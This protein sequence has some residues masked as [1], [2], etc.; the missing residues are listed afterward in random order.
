MSLVFEGREA[1]RDWR[2]RHARGM[3]FKGAQVTRRLARARG[4]A[5]KGAR[6]FT[7]RV[8]PRLGVQRSGSRQGLALKG[9]LGTSQLGVQ[10]NAGHFTA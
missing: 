10:I 3:A 1:R 2:S 7:A 8:M 6:H 5:L 9:V 4:L